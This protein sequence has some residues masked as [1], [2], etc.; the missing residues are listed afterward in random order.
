M[1]PHRVVL[2]GFG[3]VGAR[4]AEELLPAARDGRVDLTIVGAESHD[5]YNRIMIAEYAAGQIDRQALTTAVAEDFAAAGA[6]V[7]TGRRVVRID[8]PRSAVELDDGERVAFDRLVRA[9]QPEP[10]RGADLNLITGRILTQYQSG[11]QTRRIPELHAAAPRPVALL[12]PVTAMDRGI[13]TGSR[14]RLTNARGTVEADVELT[15]DIRPDTVFL[16]FHYPGAESANLLTSAATDPHSSMPEFKRTVV[17]VEPIPDP[18]G[19]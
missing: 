13:R 6:S 9:R 14:V 4:F 7:L 19:P 5:P 18:A 17:A 3:P 12:H 2:V 11:A 16:P 1:S 8:R 15:D 10:P